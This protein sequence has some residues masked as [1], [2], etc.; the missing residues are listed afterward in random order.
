MY[1]QCCYKDARIMLHALAFPIIVRNT[2]D[3]INAPTKIAVTLLKL[4]VCA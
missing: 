4:E 3:D 2:A 1:V